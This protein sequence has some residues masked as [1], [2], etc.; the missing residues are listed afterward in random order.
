MLFSDHFL[1]NGGSG[2]TSL[3][4][5]L[6][7][8]R[9]FVYLYPGVEKSS[10]LSM[11]GVISSPS[12]HQSGEM[13]G[14]GEGTPS[15]MPP[16]APLTPSAHSS[17][18]PSHSHHPSGQF[19]PFPNNAPGGSVGLFTP[20]TPGLHGL[21]A[22]P[23]GVP[24]PL[25]RVPLVHAQSAFTAA[26]AAAAAS[27][28]HAQQQRAHHLPHPHSFPSM[29]NLSA[30]LNSSNLADGLVSASS[31]SPSCPSSGG[32][33]VEGEG[34]PSSSLTPPPAPGGAQ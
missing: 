24:N 2:Y 16:H 12:I 17:L 34:Q 19:Q 22:F 6:L 15:S 5:L 14:G 10:V 13:N 32:S 26:Q 7:L 27:A 11:S 33:G 18:P 1:L 20:P 3:S 28:T 30:A 31:S 29:G 9:P 4:E 21:H 23:F 25:E 8:C